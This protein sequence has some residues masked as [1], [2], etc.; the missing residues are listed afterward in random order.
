MFVDYAEK[1]HVRAL[2]KMRMPFDLGAERTPV[3]IEMV[4]R[5]R[6]LRIAYPNNRDVARADC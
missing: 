4:D 5:D 1:R 2:R 6:A 3:E